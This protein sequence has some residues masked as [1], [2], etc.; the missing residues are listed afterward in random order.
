MAYSRR[1]VNMK[2]NDS[3]QPAAALKNSI[4]FIPDIS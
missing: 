2:V 3:E 1:V 4:D